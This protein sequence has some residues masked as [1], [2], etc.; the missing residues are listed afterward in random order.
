MTTTADSTAGGGA[1]IGPADMQ[2]EAARRQARIGLTLA[3]AVILGWL[4][5]HVY[6]VFFHRLEGWGWLGAVPLIAP[7]RQLI[8]QFSQ[9]VDVRAGRPGTFGWNVA[10]RA[11]VGFC[12]LYSGNQTDIAQLGASVDDQYVG[13][14]DVPVQELALVQIAQDLAELHRIFDQARDG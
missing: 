11:D 13:R 2:R 1:G 9:A 12:F 14:L 3:A 8:K 5:V 4:V 6:A 10:L 7:G